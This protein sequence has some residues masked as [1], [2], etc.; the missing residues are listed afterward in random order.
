MVQ[1]KIHVFELD[2]RAY[3]SVEPMSALWCALEVSYLAMQLL[4]GWQGMIVLVL[5]CVLTLRYHAG[6]LALK[7]LWALASGA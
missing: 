3:G 4:P 5:P 6:F 1:L 2:P 7:A